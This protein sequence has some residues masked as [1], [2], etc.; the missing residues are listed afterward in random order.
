MPKRKKH[1]PPQ[2]TRLL[3]ALKDGDYVSTRNGRKKY[4]IVRIDNVIWQLKK[5]GYDINSKRVQHGKSY[6]KRYELKVEQEPAQP[7]LLTQPPV[8]T[9]NPAKSVKRLAA[10]QQKQ[11]SLPVRLP[12]DQHADLKIVAARYRTTCQALI[13]L[14]IADII[15]E[16]AQAEL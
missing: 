8:K 1:L 12:E 5:A 9:P 4:G 16:A 15:E 14:A 11:K 3:A 10:L 2:A 6:Y 13:R 7:D